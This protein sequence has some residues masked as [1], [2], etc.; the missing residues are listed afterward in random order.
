[1]AVA[2]GLWGSEE[3][4]LAEVNRRAK[5]LGMTDSTFR[6]PHGLPPG[7]GLLPDQTTAR[8][9]AILAQYCVLHPTLM[10]WTNQ[11][12]ITFRTESGVR[13]NTNKLLWSVPGCDGMKTGYTRAAGWCLTA[14]AERDGIRLIAVVMGYADKNVRFQTAQRLLEDGFATLSRRLVLAKGQPMQLP[15]QVANCATPTVQLVAA[16]DVWVIVPT[17]NADQV[18]IVPQQPEV[19]QA[20]ADAGALVGEVHV[21]LNGRVLAKAPLALTEKLD[22]AGWRW[23]MQQSVR[24]TGEWLRRTKQIEADAPAK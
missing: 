5:E 22:A 6:S 19:I 8:D 17:A 13:Y 11:Q 18:E 20:P 10:Q 4:Y 12:Q 15:V 2:E 23:K 9:M 16:D 21:R 1:M 7:P 24:R 14:T 3:A